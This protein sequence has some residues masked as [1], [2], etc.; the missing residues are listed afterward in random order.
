[1]PDNVSGN[2]PTNLVGYVAI[3]ICCKWQWTRHD[4]LEKGSCARTI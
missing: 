4:H 1:L 3:L 2:F